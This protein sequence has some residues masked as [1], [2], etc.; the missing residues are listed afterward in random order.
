MQAFRRIVVLLMVACSAH[1][2]IAQTPTGIVQGTVTDS[3]G[4]SIQGASIS[5][6]QTETNETRSTTTD[7]SGRY[8]LPFV[9]P[10]SYTVTV[11]AAGFRPASQQNILVE[12]TQTRA[13]DFKLEVGQVTEQV[14]V[15]AT[16][17]NLDVDTSSLGETIQ[18]QLITELPDNG[19]NPFDFALLVPGVNNTGNAST[20]H[21]GGSR[22][23]NNEQQID[24]MTNILPENNI[25]NNL[26][27]YNPIVD[28]VQEVNVQTSVLSADYG[29]FS[30]GTISLVTKSGTNRFHGTLFEFAQSNVLNANVFSFT[31]QPKPDTHRYQSGGTVGGPILF[32][33]YNGRDKSFFFFAYEDSRE[34]DGHAA[35]Y[36][37][38]QPQWYQSGD[39]TNL[40]TP[41]YDPF[42]VHKDASGNYVR[43]P[44][45]GDD[46]TPNKIP[47]KYLNTAG[48]Q[49]AQKAMAYYPKPNVSGAGLF[50][51]FVQVGTS[52]NNY[53]HYDARLDHDV[54][55]KWHSFLRFSQFSNDSAPLNDYNDAASPGGYNGPDHAT[56]LSV[57]FN[58][59]VTF[60]PKLLGEFRYGFSK[61]TSVRTTFKSSGF[62][63]TSLGFPSSY[64][65]Q[66]ELAGAAVFPHFG[67]SE[68][69]SDLGPQ[70]YIPLKEDPL[71]Q[72]VNG[73]LVKIL[74]GHSI[75]L[76]GEYRELLLD[77]YQYAYPT[78]T[79]SVDESWTRLNPGNNDGTGNPMASLLL[80]LPN[81]G[82]YL[83]NEP[84]VVST[85]GY[86][87][88]YVQDNWSVTRKLTL[89]LGL[90]WDVEVPRVEKHNQMSYWNP[91]ASSP[92]GQ[93][94]VPAGVNCPNCGNL[95]GQMVLV[96]TSASKY[97]RRQGPIQWKDWA[98][99]IGLAYNPTPK[100]VVRSGF[101]II[102]QPSAMQAAGTSGAPGIEGFTSQ[103]NLNTTTDNEQSA[104]TFDL[105]NPY[106]AGY[107]LPQAKIAS[108][109]ASPAC[110]Q[111]IDIGSGVQQSFFDSYRTPYSIEA[112]ASAQ[113]ALPGNIK[114]E[115]GYLRNR[116]IYLINGDPGR[117]YDQLP[118][119]L[120]AQGNAL[121]EQVAN[122]FYGV[123]TVPGSSLANPTIQASQLLRKWPQYAGVS[124]F[125]KPGASSTYN[126]FTLRADKQFSQGLTF[127]FSFTDG[128]AYD[129]A[130]SAVNYLGPASQTYADQYNP[131]AE[132]G[133][134][135]QNVSYQLV[136]SFVYELPFGHG[137]PYL[138]STGTALGALLGGWQVGG[139]EN[140][141]TGTPIVLASVDNGSTASS[142]FTFGQRPAWSGKSAKVSNPSRSQWFDTSVFSKPA[143]FTIGN[144]P[145]TLSDV[146]I[147]NSQSFDFSLI[148]NNR[149]GERF[150][151]QIRLEMFNALNHPV[152]GSPDANVNDGTF[153]TISGYSNT[154]RHI[155]LAAKFIF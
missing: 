54:T 13:V 60:S 63:L 50:N 73:S 36:S 49:I 4:A 57:S 114:L 42:S 128:R 112:N 15:S 111:G 131:K 144:A 23:A 80:G 88:A 65:A 53:W 79:F 89:N 99:R 86:I 12:V 82:S 83:P 59:T 108:C 76:G 150:N 43:D 141:A 66:S 52:F 97:G 24:G 154:E 104:P 145:R 71:A 129:N 132:W 51:N 11:R 78:G 41:L 67:F 31:K 19:R 136:S 115:V 91:T 8:S 143:P 64:A 102:F 62:T 118:T 20:P 134:S 37:V 105:S 35:T 146:H 93:V 46:G 81:N 119:N 56:A 10:G 26:S 44:L 28:S 124:S 121:K 6:T 133:I 116:G 40:S 142:I 39:F 55:K 90:R 94:S 33:S 148:K 98:P 48:S 92:L 38:P 101:G 27:A 30:G 103:T 32:P 45:V 120:L 96:G 1:F 75:K 123:I 85:S 22:N 130:A 25:G 139:L 107:N 153:G 5:I 147:P 9:Q 47:S 95:M 155:Q 21:I 69:Y 135:A 100:L 138:N 61:S 113:Y 7:S 14:Q 151:T 125:R 34:S 2:L 72:D 149:F 87:G 74:G 137:K 68:G 3:S 18:T 16:T 106:P 126:A 117:P 17:E 84:S 109:L 152:L 122:P 110:V 140:W 127:T 70:G 29:R 58:N 77:F